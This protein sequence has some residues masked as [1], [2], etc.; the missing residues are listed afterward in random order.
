[1]SSASAST[2]SIG[3]TPGPAISRTPGARQGRFFAGLQFIERLDNALVAEG[4]LV[5]HRSRNRFRHVGEVLGVPATDRVVT[6]DHV[7]MWH[8]ENGKII[9]HWGGMDQGHGCTVR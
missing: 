5:V 7:E 6:V 8:V 4:D 2:T 1:M 9:E 3:P